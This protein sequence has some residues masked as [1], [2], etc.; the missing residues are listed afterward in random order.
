MD[1]LHLKNSDGED[2]LQSNCQPHHKYNQ[3][4]GNL[5]GVKFVTND[6]PNS[7]KISNFAVFFRRSAFTWDEPEFTKG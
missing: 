3:V 6:F 2:A 4:E 7:H 5:N 1:W